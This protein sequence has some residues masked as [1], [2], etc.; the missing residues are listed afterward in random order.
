MESVDIDQVAL[1]FNAGSRV[2][3]NIIL[4]FIMFGVALSLRVDDFRQVAAKPRAPLVAL[5]SQF[6]LLPACTWALTQLLSLPA[7][8]SLGMILVAACPGG[9]MSNFFTHLVRGNTALSVAVTSVGTLAAIIMTPL[10]VSFWGG[11]SP[12]TAAILTTLHVDPLEMVQ[13][14]VLLIGVPLAAGMGLRRIWPSGADRLARPF[15]ILSLLLFALLLIVAFRA[16]LHPFL[17]IIGIIFVPVL[18]HNAMAWS[19]GLGASRL[20]GLSQADTRAVGVEVA[21]QNSGLGLVLVFG[22]FDGLGGMA[23]VAA[24][25]GIWHIVAGLA[26]AGFWLW[27]DNRRAVQSASGPSSSSSAAS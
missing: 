9:N 17:A 2:A 26:M 7:T 15:K 13:T 11:L 25:W 8:V 5:A 19:I 24:W 4:G 20:A 27:R 21:I 10:N 23:V 22:F 18:V 1:A 16:N 14:V 12:Q 3:L 6:F